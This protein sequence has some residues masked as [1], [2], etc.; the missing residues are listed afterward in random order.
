[1]GY[2]TMNECEQN[3]ILN[4]AEESEKLVEPH[5]A[6]PRFENFELVGWNGE[7]QP[8]L[9]KSSN[10]PE[11][12]I[13]TLS[14]RKANQV[15]LNP[16]VHSSQ[17]PSRLSSAEGRKLPSIAVKNL[18]PKLHF[19]QAP[20]QPNFSPKH[21]EPVQLWKFSGQESPSRYVKR[22]LHNEI[23]KKSELINEFYSFKPIHRNM[24]V[25]L[26]KVKRL[27]VRRGHHS[28]ME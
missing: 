19:V 1:M 12:P 21:L 3:F 8:L 28:S 15:H 22:S 23:I 10:P 13:R 7:F 16:R 17:L 20:F 18:I 25:T 27:K 9:K 26:D 14:H 4:L 11:K 2:I 6:V 5:S 24:E